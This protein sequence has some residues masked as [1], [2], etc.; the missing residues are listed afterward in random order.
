M[1]IFPEHQKIFTI[2][3]LAHYSQYTD[4]VM[5]SVIVKREGKKKKY[6]AKKQQRISIQYPNKITLTKKLCTVTLTKRL[7]IKEP[8]SPEKI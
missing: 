7:K 5:L 4:Q 2:K 1:L 3:N 8:I 6:A